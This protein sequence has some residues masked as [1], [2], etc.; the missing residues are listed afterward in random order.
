[1]KQAAASL[2]LAKYLPERAV[3]D[4]IALLRKHGVYLKLKGARSTKWGDFYNQKRNGYYYISINR[5]LNP[6]QFL[7]TLVH[8]L[9]HLTTLEKF[10]SKVPH[11]GKEWKSEFKRLMEPFLK[12]AYFPPDLLVILK[13]HMI[14]PKAA[15][16]TDTVLFKKLNAYSENSGAG[17]FVEDLNS[18]E[19]FI[20]KSR[21]YVRGHQIK[22]RILC[23]QVE[24]KRKFLFSPIA[25][26]EPW[27][28]V[29]K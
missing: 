29:E 25:R 28:D 19:E 18:G 2:T 3:P 15:A 16:T 1:M 9:A 23:I 21:K 8:E 22:K 17:V 12:E 5:N 4:I 11:H 26:V 10:G 7:M 6:Y 14:N 13:N 27:T 20:Y 24:T